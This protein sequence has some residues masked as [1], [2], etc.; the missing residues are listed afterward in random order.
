M[1]TNKELLA[2]V[3]RLSGLVNGAIATAPAAV[4]APAVTLQAPAGIPQWVAD[5]Q[6][7]KVVKPP[8]V[9]A[10]PKPPRPLSMEVAIR[11]PKEGAEK[12]FDPFKVLLISNGANGRFHRSVS[13][14][15]RYLRK[16][17]EF[18]ASPQGAAFL[19]S[20]QL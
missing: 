16:V 13:L 8:K 19:K 15:S 18:L 12:T 1:V 11:A 20:G 14:D 7:V 9:A 17:A 3:A 10:A 2:E 5:A 6:P 4:A